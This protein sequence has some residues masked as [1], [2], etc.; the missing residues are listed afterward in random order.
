MKN[1]EI[2]EAV[3]ILNSGGLV[4]MPT[5]TIY[6]VHCVALEKKSV[7]HVYSVR[8]R[9]AGKPCIIL[10]SQIDQIEF[11]GIGVF[12]RTRNFFKKVW[13]GKASIIIPV[14]RKKQEEFKFLHRGIGSLG[15][16]MPNLDWLRKVI[17]QT[18]PLLSTSANL[19]GM[20]PA[21]SI[22]EA[23]KYF[24]SEIGFYLDGGEID[25]IPSSLAEIE[26]GKLRVLRKGE[27]DLEKV[28]F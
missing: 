6:G 8:R 25:S 26:N 5:D 18:G 9:D 13:P 2:A 12:P 15:F 19:Q 14:S 3:K 17:D 1:R 10:I 22:G 24:G 27:I 11:F 21:R 7:E 16:R 20:P 4:V 23:R 28:D